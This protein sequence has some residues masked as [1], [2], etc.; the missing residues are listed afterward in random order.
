[1]PSVPGPEEAFM[2]RRKNAK[3]A[4]SPSPVPVN[5]D[6]TEERQG[7]HGQDA[8]DPRIIHQ[9]FFVC[10]FLLSNQT[11]SF[12]AFWM[13]WICADMFG[14]LYKGTGDQTTQF[15]GF[16]FLADRR[17]FSPQYLQKLIRWGTDKQKRLERLRQEQDLRLKAASLEGR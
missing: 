4:T 5:V 2:R 13:S 10:L 7:N 16:L 1:M 8:A 11:Q 14:P 17:F 9:S 15:L 3:P 6:E 12:D